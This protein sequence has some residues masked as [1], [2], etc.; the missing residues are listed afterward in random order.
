MS[1]LVLTSPSDIVAV[2]FTDHALIVTL[3]DARRVEAP[4]AQ[5]PRL[6]HA[7]PAQRARWRLI[8]GGSGIHWEDLDEDLSLRSL[9]AP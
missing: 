5:Y 6:L 8:G 2:E 4:L 7:T 3:A 1:T 9:R